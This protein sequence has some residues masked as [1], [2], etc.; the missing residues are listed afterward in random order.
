M[1]SNCFSGLGL[2]EQKS[3]LWEFFYG[4]NRIKSRAA[5]GREFLLFFFK[6]P[7]L[8]LNC[9]R[10]QKYFYIYGDGTLETASA[11]LLL[12]SQKIIRRH[13]GDKKLVCITARFTIMSGAAIS[14]RSY[15]YRANIL[16]AKYAANVF[17]GWENPSQLSQRQRR[18]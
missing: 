17:G 1:F 14:Y 2:P 9:A 15:K 10:T 18:R 12:Y 16:N 6:C 13:C 4:E 8:S 11:H 5:G 3:Q 7:L